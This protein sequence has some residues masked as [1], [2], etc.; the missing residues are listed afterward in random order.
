MNGI[1]FISCKSAKDRTSMSITLEQ[2]SILKRKHNLQ[3][4]TFNHAIDAMRRYVLCLRFFIQFIHDHAC[5][6]S[7]IGGSMLLE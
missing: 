2:C 6:H 4:E 7:G 3:P 1:R 5:L